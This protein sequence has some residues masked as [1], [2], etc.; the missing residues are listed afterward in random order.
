MRDRRSNPRRIGDRVQM[1]KSPNL[2]AASRL[3]GWRMAGP[4]GFR[5]VAEGVVESFGGPGLF[6]YAEELFDDLV[7]TVEWRLSLLDDN[8]GLFLRCPPLAD[9]PQPAIEHGYEIQ[10]DDRGLDPEKQSLE[11][12]L[13]F[14]GA[15]YQLAP[16][17]RFASRPVGQWNRFEVHAIGSTISVV[18][19]GEEVSRL[20][21]A[22]R[23]P[24][25]HIG[26]Q[27]HHAGSAVQFRNLLVARP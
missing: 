2:L 13:H 17:V 15:I 18:L 1:S 27:N 6:W 7:L 22:S 16:A 3:S 4:G 25:G 8:S 9:S 14:T 11:S 5:N 23:Q 10:I 12:P 19:N 26:L 20:E 24:V 21:G